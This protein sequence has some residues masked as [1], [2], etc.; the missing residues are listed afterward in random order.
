MND[1]NRYQ[2]SLLSPRIPCNSLKL[3]P[4]IL[5]VPN[6][7]VVHTLYSYFKY[8]HLLLVWVCDRHVIDIITPPLETKTTNPLSVV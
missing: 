4:H 2:L 8:H 3:P 5:L 1:C 7:F 6:S